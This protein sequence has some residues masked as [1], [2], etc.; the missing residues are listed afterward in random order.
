VK[1]ST[2]IYEM[3]KTVYE[4]EALSCMSLNHLKDAEREVSTL[5]MIHRMGCLNPKTVKKICEIMAQDCRMPLKVME[6]KL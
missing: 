5:K 1:I 3:L 2:E 4:N 6:N